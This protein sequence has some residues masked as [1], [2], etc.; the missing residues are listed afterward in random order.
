MRGF[1]IFLGLAFPVVLFSPYFWS[2]VNMEVGAERVGY[3]RNGV[4]QWATL[5]PQA[6]WPPWAIVPKGTR[7]TVRSN[8]EAAPGEVA[9][10]LGDF[11]A[12][13]AP[14]VIG[15][16]YEDALRAASWAVTTWRFDASSPDIPPQPI[17]DCIIEGRLKG[18]VLRLVLDIADERAAGSLHWTEGP[19][20]PLKGA[21]EEAC[22]TTR[23]ER[24]RGR[25]TQFG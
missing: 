22:W 5:G 24:F 10:G 3:V 14:A 20:P 1:L 16:A 6:P 15:P 12:D 13:D 19:L 21:R 11:E 7:F 2:L 8:F 9:T 17:H 18:R 23:G 4:T 25:D